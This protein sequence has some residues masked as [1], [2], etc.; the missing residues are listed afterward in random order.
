MKRI[1]MRIGDELAR[2]VAAAIE[3]RRNREPKLSLNDYILEA[4]TAKAG[5]PG[6]DDIYRALVLNGSK[7]L[8]DFAEADLNACMD[9]LNGYGITRLVHGAYIAARWIDIG[10][11]DGVRLN[12]MAGKWSIDGAALVEKVR[13]LST[14]GRFALFDLADRFWSDCQSGKTVMQ[15]LA[16][17]RGQAAAPAPPPP[18]EK[19]APA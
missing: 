19:Q 6:H 10:I 17:Q 14:E 13:N 12:D 4:I 1:T 5:G 16:D 8:D 11:A 18:A 2:I 15:F 7:A 9:V 3:Q